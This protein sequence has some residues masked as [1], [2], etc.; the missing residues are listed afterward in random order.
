MTAIL[1]GVVLGPDGAPLA[2]ARV[3]IAAAPVAVPDIALETSADGR[4][5]LAAPAAGAYVIG[6]TS[7]GGA[8]RQVEILVGDEA[9]APVTVRLPAD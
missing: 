5:S 8:S 4:F 6:V 2:G 3:G 1:S 9:P 7:P